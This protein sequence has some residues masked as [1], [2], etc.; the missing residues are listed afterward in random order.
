MSASRP[1][2][3]R[4]FVAAHKR[5]RMMDAMAEL[6]AE[7][8]YE[9]TKIADVV[10]RAKVARKTLYDNFTGKEELFLASFDTAVAEAE[11]AVDSAC[12]AAGPADG[13]A[14]GAR[15]EAGLEGFLDFVAVHPHASRL[16]VVDAPG[17]F[18]AAAAH[19]DA[20]VDRFVTRLRDSAP[21]GSGRPATLE[22]ALVGGVAWIVHQ[23]VRGAGG[24]VAPSDLLPQ[25][26][27][28]VLTPYKGVAKG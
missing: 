4:E 28:F 8:G 16:C 14:W 25:L 3:P 22:E 19:Y 17:A 26:R 27:E 2:L 9:A 1:E 5:R 15:M 11:A 24:G 13:T 21:A 18:A 23:H 10:R 12:D 7:K 6:C 20:A